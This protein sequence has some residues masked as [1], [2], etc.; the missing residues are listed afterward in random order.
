MRGWGGVLQEDLAG[1]GDGAE[2]EGS[3][4]S[5]GKMANGHGVYESWKHGS[6]SYAARGKFNQNRMKR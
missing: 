2:E 6:H 3:K 5:V 1:S 4:G